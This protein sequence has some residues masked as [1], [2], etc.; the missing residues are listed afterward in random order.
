MAN[1]AVTSLAE[2]DA[3]KNYPYDN[4][5][6]LVNYSWIGVT[7]SDTPLQSP[8]KGGKYTY[9]IE[10]DFGGATFNLHYSRTGNNF[11]ILD[12]ALI[13]T[14]SAS[15]NIEIASGY[16]KPVISSGASTSANVYV[17]PIPTNPS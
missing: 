1:I 2:Y 10:G 17:S 6:N 12:D 3:R 13:L 7:E 14:S 15:K 8:I 5:I 4:I 16:I 11:H 9:T